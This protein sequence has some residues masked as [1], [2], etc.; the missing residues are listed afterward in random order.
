MINFQ[1]DTD[2]IYLYVEDPYEAKYQ[3][4][5]RENKDLKHLLNVRM[6]WAIFIKILKNTFKIKNK[7][8]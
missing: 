3:F 6:I 1:Q 2:K 8:H 7:K 4:L 5:I